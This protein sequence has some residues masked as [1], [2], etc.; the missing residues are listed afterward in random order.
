MF[1][2]LWRQGEAAEPAEAEP[3]ESE[4]SEPP[5]PGR[6]EPE[7]PEEPLGRL[8]PQGRGRQRNRR[9]CQWTVEQRH[10]IKAR[11]LET[12]AKRLEE[13]AAIAESLALH[14][15]SS[16]LSL[17]ERFADAF[18]ERHRRGDCHRRQRISVADVGT[19]GRVR[20]CTNQK[21]CLYHDRK[22]AAVSHVRG[23]KS[24]I[25]KYLRSKKRCVV[26]VCMDDANVW[27]QCPTDPM[28]PHRKRSLARRQGKPDCRGRN[29]HVPVMNNV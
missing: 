25:G 12:K 17:D 21:Q 15:S 10:K 6:L 3:A 16:R 11:K 28:C 14:A 23:V 29:V 7:A 20:T 1:G 9:G 4:A 24:G 13:E 27:V 19:A 2:F 26:T 18:A 8:E 5:G 22:R